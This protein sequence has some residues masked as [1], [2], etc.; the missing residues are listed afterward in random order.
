MSDVPLEFLEDPILL[1]ASELVQES[2]FTLAGLDT[3]D[4]CWDAVSVGAKI[5]SNVF[6]DSFEDGFEDYM[7]NVNDRGK[8]RVKRETIARNLLKGRAPYH[9]IH[10]A[11]GLSLEEKNEKIYFE[12]I[13]QR[14]IPKMSE[15][16]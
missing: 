15:H 2:S 9:L 4:R 11:T 12:E 7:E 5:K 6:K 13:T 8:A 3:H 10:M 14:T 1:K 16:W